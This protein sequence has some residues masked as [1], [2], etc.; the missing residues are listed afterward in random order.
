[1]KLLYSCNSESDR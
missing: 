1:M